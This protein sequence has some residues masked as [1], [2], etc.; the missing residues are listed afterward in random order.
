R[1]VEQPRQPR[2]KPVLNR[3]PLHVVQQRLDLFGGRFAPFAFGRLDRDLEGGVGDVFVGVF[4]GACDGRFA[5]R[6][7]AAAGRRAVQRGDR[8]GGV[9]CRGFVGQ[10]RAAGAG[11]RDGHVGRHFDHRRG[12]V[13]GGFFRHRDFEGGGGFVAR[14][15][16]GRARHGRFAEREGG[17]RFGAAFDRHRAVDVVT[18]GAGVV[19][20]HRSRGG[21]RFG[22]DVRRDA[23][24]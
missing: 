18:G 11:R 7:G 9:G 15:V 13:F 2:A 24:Q 16:F 10:D 8:V 1:V 19:G 3:R 20:D 23:P 14:L 4:R 22:A 6:E 12:F 5:E 17:A 21:R